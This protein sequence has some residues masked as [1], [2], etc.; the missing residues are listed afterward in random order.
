MKLDLV[1]ERP[2]E[3]AQTVADRAELKEEGDQHKLRRDHHAADKEQVERAVKPEF[4]TRKR[5]GRHRPEGEDP[6]E[7][8]PGHDHAVHEEGAEVRL[9]PRV[10]EVP[11]RGLGGRG[12]IRPVGVGRPGDQPRQPEGILVNLLRTADGI[13]E[14]PDHRQH[15]RREPEQQHRVGQRFR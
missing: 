4:E 6:C 5:V 13:A 1:A 8:N 11:H 14:H 12:H 2:N 3:G 10:L 7:R 9:R 15:D